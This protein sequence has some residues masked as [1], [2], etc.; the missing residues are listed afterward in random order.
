MVKCRPKGEYILQTMVLHRNLKPFVTP[1]LGSPK[2][3]EEA[4][5]LMPGGGDLSAPDLVD[6]MAS[7][8]MSTET[9]EALV[10]IS[11]AHLTKATL[12]IET[13]LGKLP[14]GKRLRCQLMRIPPLQRLSILIRSSLPFTS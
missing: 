5:R 10:A 12:V 3:L 8:S 1:Q 2:I 6:G 7:L 4:S 9:T 13:A 14:K 11:C